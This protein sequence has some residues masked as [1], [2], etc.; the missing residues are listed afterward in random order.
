MM[1]G[2]TFHSMYCARPTGEHDYFTSPLAEMDKVF[3]KV[4]KTLPSVGRPTRFITMTSSGGKTSL[5][6]TT[7]V[8]GEKAF[9]LKFNESRDM[10]W[11]DT[12]F[13]AKYDEQENT[14][15]KLLPFEGDKH[16]YEDELKEVEKHLEDDFQ[17]YMRKQEEVKIL[18]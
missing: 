2:I 15:E 11:M 6:G 10:D 13:L 16:F 9:V 3:S 18:V 14:I 4:Y 5:L 12:V 1:L 7:M 8:N 17:K